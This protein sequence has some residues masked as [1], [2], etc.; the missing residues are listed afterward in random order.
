MPTLLPRYVLREVLKM[1]A[2][3][4]G[5]MFALQMTD[6]ISG[7]IGTAL[8]Y[9]ASAAEGLTAFLALLPSFLNRCLVLAVP[10]AILLG[11]SRLQSDSEVKALLAGG[12]RP[13]SLVWPLLLPFGLAGLLAFWNA[14]SI[15]PAGR[16]RWDATWYGI[17]GMSTPVPSREGYTYA[18]AGALYYAGR[19]T[20][21]GTQAAQTRAGQTR[22]DQTRGAPAQLSGVMVERGGEVYTSS[23][24]QWDPQARTWTLQGAWVVRPGQRPESLPQPV[25]LPQTDDLRPPPADTKKVSNAGL[26]AALASGELSPQ[27]TREYR[28]AL[29]ARYADPFTPL[30]FA[31]AAGA[32]GLLLPNR[33]A[34]MAAVI[35]FIAGFYVVWVTMPSLASGGAIEPRLAAWVPS[36]LFLALGLG[37]TWKLRAS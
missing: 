24:G 17:Y 25:T 20:G 16:E 10:F 8:T 34:A 1:Y 9:R 22:A 13:V 15:E 30:A 32:L 5:L 3:G 7:T 14:S 27:E 26:R 4:F 35:L 28:Y 36:L 11:L 37:L 12:V 23:V 33:A 18:P 19:V 21:G 31:L 29:A 6:A 2:V